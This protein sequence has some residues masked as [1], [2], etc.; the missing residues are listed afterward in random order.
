MK[1]PL[2]NGIVRIVSLQF[3]VN[4]GITAFDYKISIR[5]FILKLD[6]DF[7]LHI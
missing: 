2:K 3:C 1:I 7:G 6:N 4:I 5:N